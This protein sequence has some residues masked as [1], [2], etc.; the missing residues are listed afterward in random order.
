MA[1]RGRSGD[2]A[3]LTAEL[4]TSACAVRSCTVALRSARGIVLVFG[5]AW[6]LGT[7][8]APQAR[9]QDEAITVNHYTHAGCSIGDRRYLPAFADTGLTATFRAPDGREQCLDMID[10][11]QA[12]CEMATHFQPTNPAGRP[13]EPDE[14]DPSCIGVF[15]AEVPLCID[16]YERQ[17]HRCNRDVPS[18][19][20]ERER[21]A[22]EQVRRE[23]ERQALEQVRR[24]RE[25]QAL[26]QA[27]AEQRLLWEHERQAALEREREEARRQRERVVRQRQEQERRRL[28]AL[29]QAR[30]RER[31]Q[32]AP[33]LS[34][35]DIL[36]GV[37]QSLMIANQIAQL[38]GDGGG[39]PSP[40]VPGLLPS[41]GIGGTMPG[42]VPRA[43]A[44]GGACR[45]AQRRVAARL[46]AQQDEL[47][48]VDGGICLL[49]RRG[50]EIGEAALREMRSAGCPP[51]ELGIYEQY[52]AD[53][54]KAAA[55]YDCR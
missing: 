28:A 36:T 46:S 18:A 7:F 21:Q 50:V 40:G 4:R 38:R 8:G 37:A 47:L 17:R 22:L 14:K 23:R 31:Q 33:D 19:L 52:V 30:E 35:E 13:W 55:S 9:A 25:R 51:G 32:A 1:I 48:A 15:D 45:E 20:E 34:L 11:A 6:F 53:N 39:V 5:T 27:R 43:G 49:A 3:R 2:P 44:A 24:E 12:G 26:E 16:H 41:A 29:E 54:R 42:L 10:R